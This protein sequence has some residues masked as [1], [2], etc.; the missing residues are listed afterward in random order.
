[1]TK[2]VTLKIPYSKVTRRSDF[3]NLKKEKDSENENIFP[4]RAYFKGKSKIRLRLYGIVKITRHEYQRRNYNKCSRNYRKQTKI[5]I[6]KG[7]YS[8][9][10]GLTDINGNAELNK[11]K[12][13]KGKTR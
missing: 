3:Q 10:S 12:M 13:R 2:L 7:K 1:M 8:K 11:P 6:E 5:V 4:F 9:S